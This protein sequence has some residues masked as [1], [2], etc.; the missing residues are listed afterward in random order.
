MNNSTHTVD[1]SPEQNFDPFPSEPTNDRLCY[2][3][4]CICLL[5]LE[6]GLSDRIISR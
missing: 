1:V 6:D 2:H 3:G 4:G 5:V